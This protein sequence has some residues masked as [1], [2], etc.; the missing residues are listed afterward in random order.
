MKDT[1]ELVE[2]ITDYV[3]SFSRKGPEFCTAMSS[4]HRTLQQSFTKLCLQWIEHVG[5]PDYRTDARNE[6]SKK[7][8]Q[9]LLQ[10]FREL[11]EKE[12]F[13]GD[14]LDLMSIPSGHLGC[15]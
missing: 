1:K 15:I 11:Q 3:N 13:T 5:S 8:A 4:Q 7:I 12:G 9:Q 2:E 6:D 14:T 10:Q